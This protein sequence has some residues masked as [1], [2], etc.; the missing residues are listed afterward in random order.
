MPSACEGHL[1]FADPADQELCAGLWRV[2]ECSQ[3]G[4]ARRVELIIR[5]PVLVAA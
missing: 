2:V 3:N 5:A 1:V 4:K